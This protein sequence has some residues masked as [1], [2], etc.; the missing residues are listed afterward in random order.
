MHSRTPWVLIP[1][2]NER[3]NIERMIIALFALNIPH[4]TVLIVDDNSPDGTAGVVRNLQKKYDRLKL[5]VRE[6]KAGLGRAYIHGF[7]YA[8]AAGASAVVQMDADFSH[9][10]ADVPRL[11][12]K[13]TTHALVLGSRYAHGISVINWP[14]RR[15]LISIIGNTYARL[16]T[17]IPYKD[18]TGG[19]K[20]WRAQALQAIALEQIVADGYG[21]QIVATY[22]AWKKGL[23]IIEIPIVFT[24]RREGQ[25]KMSKAII[26]EA[27][28]VVW[29]LR[30]FG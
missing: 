18:L 24:E 10:P 23:S 5:V 7:E 29:R 2:Y 4:L 27:L 30:L 1:T 13:L 15:L 9:D 12:E 25:S 6:H 14:L 3:L 28:W 8:L 26:I 16:I 11:L 20:A 21:F 17:G 19:F 22:R